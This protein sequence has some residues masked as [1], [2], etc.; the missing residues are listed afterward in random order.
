MY[1]LAQPTGDQGGGPPRRAGMN[2]VS[3]SLDFLDFPHDHTASG[4]NLSPRITLGD[5]SPAA[6][7][8]AVMVTNPFIRTCCSFTPWLI[9][10][11]P[12][13]T[14]IPPGIPQKGVT[15]EPVP[16]V[17]GTNGYGTTGYTGPNPPAG[18]TH[19]YQFRVYVLDTMVQVP[20]GAG[21]QELVDAMKGHVL[22]YGET[23]AI[24]TG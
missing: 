15:T 5:I 22:Q 16:S 6:V 17:Q 13:R 21:R 4:R 3:V 20:P 9:W 12:P 11:L 1:H 14:A 7:S 2:R 10:N 24:C 19:R 18:E 8:V 23:A